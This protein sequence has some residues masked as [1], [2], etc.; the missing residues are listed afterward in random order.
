MDLEWHINKF[1]DLVKDNENLDEKIIDEK[2][3]FYNNAIG[4]MSN[5][6]PVSDETLERIKNEAKSRLNFQIIKPVKIL[7]GGNFVPWFK[8]RR[9]ELDMYYWDRYERYLDSSGKFN[10]NVLE[11]ID[12]VTDD[13]TDLLGDPESETDF[14]RVGLVIGDVQSG[15][16]AN[17]IGIINK[18]ADAGYKLIVVLAGTDNELRKQT[19][20]RI[21][22]GFLGY[23]SK[24]ALMKKNSSVGVGNHCKII[25]DKRP[26][27]VTTTEKDFD[28]HSAKTLSITLDVVKSP[29]IFVMKKNVTYLKKLLNWITNLNASDHTG[30]INHSML[31]IDDEADYAS[32]N[33]NKPEDDPTATNE[34]IANLLGKFRRTSYVGFTATPF[35][36]VFI[37]PDTEKEME[38]ASLFPKDYIYCLESP[39]NYVGPNKLFGNPYDINDSGELQECVKTLEADYGD[40]NPAGSIH[41]ILPLIHKK[42]AEFD[43]LPDSL[44]YAIRTFFIANAIRDLDGYTNAHRSM[45]IN[46]SRF[47]DVQQK[48]AELVEIYVRE[49]KNSIRSCANHPDDSVRENNMVIA[50]IYNTF[51]V[52]YQDLCNERGYIWDDIRQ[53]LSKSVAN[54]EIIIKNQKSKDDLKYDKFKADGLSYRVIA[55]GGITLSRGLT[56][57]G[58]IVSYFYRSAYAYDTLMQ[59][60]RWF[61]YRSGYEKLCRIWML[62]TTQELFTDINISIIDLKNSISQYRK[63]SLTPLDFGIR[64][65]NDSSILVT[66][67]NKMRT[68]KSQDIWID[69]NGSLIETPFVYNYDGPNKNNCEA[70][71]NCI[72]QLVQTYG[73][74]KIGNTKGFINVTKDYVVQLLKNMEF[75]VE[76]TKY[77]SDAIIEFIDSEEHYDVWDVAIQSGSGSDYNITE[78]L[79]IKRTLRQVDTKRG[80]KYFRISGKRRRVGGP[81]DGAFGC[82]NIE[83]IKNEKDQYIEKDCSAQGSVSLSQSDYFI[84]DRKRNPLL[85]IYFIEPKAVENI[86][87]TEETVKK[88]GEIGN[89]SD[90]TLI[91]ISI[92]FPNF[93]GEKPK[94]IRYQTNK[95]EQSFIG[96]GRSEE[97]DSYYDE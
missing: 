23:S 36:N 79:K 57:E 81:S 33:T 11:N 48:V 90:N 6:P 76:N 26:I 22:E 74:K 25:L 95:V 10:R 62:E 9:A 71:R 51:L 60:G 34:N 16:T 1:I 83:Y 65:R 35:A 30:K 84:Y 7:T 72:E 40:S 58:L 97:E 82:T 5:L 37:D 46:V 18:A 14:S 63:S 19:Q 44:K 96:L 68:A 77:Q 94:L 61:G 92:G 53:E 28:S 69:M 13:I 47:V 55:V 20:M 91:A 21:D 31:I 50:D 12:Y 75:P 67:R 66:A 80:S 86:P 88:I 52:E 64:V 39:T 45:M 29:I 43:R 3:G 17:F 38:H 85:T 8:S 93:K 56:L 59:M 41:A 49:L 42:N 4:M 32:L 73:T 27:S 2:I 15:K 78:S 54:I 24:D 87:E 70:A 89:D